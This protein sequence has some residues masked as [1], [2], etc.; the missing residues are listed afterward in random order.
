[1]GITLPALTPAQESLF[2]TLAGKAVDSRLPHPFLGDTIADEVL[3]KSGYD[4]AKFPPLT[5]RLLAAKTKVF[6]I[7]VRAKRL[8]EVV[9]RFVDRYPNAVV[10][11]LGAGLD[12]RMLRVNPPSTVS[13]YD[14]DFP[15]VVALRRQ[16]LPEQVSA[17]SIGADVTDPNWLDE[18]PS[19]RPAVIV[20]DGL[21][22]FLTQEAFVSLLN[23]L[24]GRF[25]SGEIAFNL[26]TTWAVLGAK[27]IGPIRAG[28]VNPGFND[29][30]QPEAWVPGLKLVEE[31]FLTR[32]P[33]LAEFTSLTGR[34]MRLTSHLAALNPTVS[35]MIGTTLERYGF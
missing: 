21:V 25:P 24:T 17:H 14:V 2:L 28:V 27:R 13:W 31:I 32:A 26:Y 9:D 33:E 29:P 11:D 18:V 19:D 1:M 15:E 3:S 34:I 23:R 7:A 5:T 6:D 4:I 8:D 20:A 16:L 30:R 35:R 22:A 12:S 10:L